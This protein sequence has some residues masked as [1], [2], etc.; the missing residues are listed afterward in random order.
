MARASLKRRVT[1]I[2]SKSTQARSP[3]AAPSVAKLSA[4]Q[5]SS[6]HM[7]RFTPG[8]NHSAAPSAAKV[9]VAWVILKHTSKFTQANGRTFA[10]SA[11]RISANQVIS[12]H[13]NRFIKEN[14]PILAV[15]AVSVTIVA[16]RNLI[17]SQKYYFSFFFFFYKSYNI[18]KYIIKYICF[19]MFSYLMS[20]FLNIFFWVQ[21]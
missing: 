16:K 21:L 4:I 15:A 5:G 7:R 17:T 12:K 9:S 2:T 11:G 8:K 18:Y 20:P 19:I 14:D 10:S 6:E 1:T 13:M 3:T